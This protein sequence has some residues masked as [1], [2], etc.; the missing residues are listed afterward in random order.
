VSLETPARDGAG[1]RL[2]V[3]Y[4]AT[5]AAVQLG[6]AAVIVVAVATGLAEHVE[7]AALAVGGHTVH[8]LIDRAVRWLGRA[9][10]P[11]HLYLLA[12][13][14]TAD[15]LV[16]A[17]EGWVLHRRYAWAPWVVVGTTGAMLP[18]ELLEIARRP[19]AGLVVI[20]LLNVAIVIYLAQEASRR[21]H[22]RSRPP[23]APLRSERRR[24]SRTGADLA[25]AEAA[26][27]DPRPAR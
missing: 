16:T 9:A 22:G 2:I 24:A 14:L 3:A 15:G 8:P 12:A 7:A 10:T 20:F 21:I 19:R 13:A 6:A 25:R 5:K 26:R 17:V 23:A 4:K 18:F 27:A 1:V 11:G